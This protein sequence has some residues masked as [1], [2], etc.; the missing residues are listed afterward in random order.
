MLVSF[1]FSN[2]RSI[3]DEVDF[4]MIAGSGVER[5]YTAVK[6]Y[7]LLNSAVIFGAN[8]SG[9]SNFLRAFNYM[10]SLVLNLTKV[11][12]S[13][14]RLPH[15]PFLLNSE[16]ENSSSEFEVVFFVGDSRFRYGF[17]V[18]SEFVYSEWLF[19]SEKGKEARLFSRDVDEE[20]YVNSDK[21]KEGKG[22][23]LQ[24][25]GLFLWKCDQE[26]GE[27]S[28]K[29]LNWF[30]NT[31]VI[32]AASPSDFLNYSIRKLDEPDF[33]D[34]IIELMRS[35]DF[36]IQDI[37]VEKN[38]V[39]FDE[40]EK[41]P[42]P[43][44]L[45]EEIQKNPQLFRKVGL[46]SSH[47]KYD[48]SGAELGD[49]VLLNFLKSESEGTKKL[50]TLSAPLLDTLINGKVLFVDE[51]DASLHPHLVNSLL[52][53][54]TSKLGENSRAQLIFTTHDTHILNSGDFHKSQVWFAEKNAVESTELVS[55]A[56]YKG[57]KESDNISKKYLMGKFGAIPSLHEF[58]IV[59]GDA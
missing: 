23:R 13:T 28:K 26:G 42:L 11:I 39:P 51:L 54:F 40:F 33:R 5:N 46:R 1:K 49:S 3:K 52:S 57:I 37:A 21:F 7:N 47:K 36:S 6:N 8:A 4:S 55:L 2:F 12:Q 41:I 45:K 25:N 48:K 18:D 31:N 30:K 34:R 27:I 32:N 15:E 44:S 53:L 22:V 50:F 35:A 16:T 10:R 58:S 24:Q 43:R 56:E 19:V 59:K 20:F 9:K 29:I 14:D 17:E 38:D